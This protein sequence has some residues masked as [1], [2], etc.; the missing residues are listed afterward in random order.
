MDK[1][2][3]LNAIN[4]AL[5]DKGKRKFVQSVE[6]IINFRDIDFT[7][8]ENRL[9]LDIILP[10]GKGK[11]QKVVVFADGQT[12]LDAKNAGA[13]EIFDSEG[14]TKLK[15][16]TKKLKELIKTSEFIAQPNLM[17]SVGKV[18]GQALSKKGKLPRPITGSVK[19][20]IEQARKR[21]RLISK[22]KYLPV[23]QC[24]I[25]SEQM[26][27][28]QIAYNFEAV[29]EKIKSKIPESNIKSIYVKLSMGKPV[30]VF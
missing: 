2:T 25:G 11:Q 12:A 18:L 13:D 14:M 20:A 17:V 29:Y 21:V 22:G 10:E 5:E 4:K 8:P 15:N 19:D 30:K 27:P 1:K 24:V 9:N 23:V 28:E 16:D 6:M 7:K 3:I 26:T